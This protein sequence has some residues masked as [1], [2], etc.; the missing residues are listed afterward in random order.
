M[1]TKTHLPGVRSS[2]AL[3]IPL[4]ANGQVHSPITPRSAEL[5]GRDSHWR[6]ARGRLRVQKAAAG[7]ALAP[8]ERA[9]TGVVQQHDQPHM[10]ERPF[11]GGRHRNVVDDDTDLRFEIYSVRLARQGHIVTR[12]DEIIGRSLVHER[13]L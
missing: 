13:D 5:V 4:D 1:E 7:L 2:E 12:S 8:R 11:S 6:K 3:T 9:Q 10:L